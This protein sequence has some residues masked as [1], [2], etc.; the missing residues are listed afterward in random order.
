MHCTYSYGYLPETKPTRI[1]SI[2]G[3]ST[4]HKKVKVKAERVC[5]LGNML[6]VLNVGGELGMDMIMIYCTHM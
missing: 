1:V 2:P 3:D 5:S 6:R 4:N